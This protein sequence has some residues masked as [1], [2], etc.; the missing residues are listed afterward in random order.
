MSEIKTLR[1]NVD[2]DYD[3]TNTTEEGLDRLVENIG[4]AVDKVLEDEKTTEGTG[5][6]FMK[7]ATEVFFDVETGDLDQTPEE[8]FEE[9]DL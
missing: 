2:V 6:N 4:A 7:W 1:I 5:V 9:D 3:A 8:A